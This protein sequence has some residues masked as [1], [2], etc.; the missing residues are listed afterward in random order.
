MNYKK[1]TLDT[2]R[3]SFESIVAM[4]GDNKSRYIEATIVNRSIPVDLTGCTV[5]F[6]AIKP[7]ITDIFNDTVIS[8]AKGGK[9]QIE[10]TNQTL[11]VPGVIQ[12]TLVIL[13]EDMQLS[14]L[15]FFITVIENPYNSNAIESK[16]EYKALNNALTI[17]E[18]YAKELQDA[19]VNLEEKYT[20]RLNNFDSQLDKKANQKEL[21]IERKRID[22]F[23]SLKED[24][25]T[26]DAELIDGRV[27]EDGI[28]YENIGG[29]VRNQLKKVNQI[30]SKEDINFTIN[31]YFINSE[32]EESELE[33][34]KATDFIPVKKGDIV[35][36]TGLGYKTNV[37]G[38]YLFDEFKTKIE[39]LQIL[40]DN[41]ETY[42]KIVSVNGYI[43]C[44]GRKNKNDI[45]LGSIT[46]L[47]SELVKYMND[48]D[49]N[50]RFNITNSWINGGYI[51]YTNGNITEYDGYSYSDYI[52]VSDLNGMY[53]YVTEYYQYL[54]GI[55]FYDENKKFI[56]GIGIGG[57]HAH[58]N[59]GQIT[60]I[61]IEG[62]YMR[63]TCVTENIH[64]YKLYTS[65]K[66]LSKSINYF[67]TKDIS[68]NSKINLHDNFNWTKG[69]YI[70]FDSGEVVPLSNDYSYSDFINISNINKL[71]VELTEY[72][73][74]ASGIA[75][76]D[77]NK[78][79][80]SGIKCESGGVNNN[81][82][83][84]IKVN[85]KG[86]YMRITCKTAFI[87]KFKLSFTLF[88]LIFN[89]SKK[90]VN[91]CFYKDNLNLIKMFNKIVC[92]G[93]SYT[94]GAI[95]YKTTDGRQLQAIEKN[96]SYP[97][98]LSK[99]ANVETVNLGHAG[100]T[101]SKWFSKYENVNL[102]GY[103][104]AIIF[105]GI[106]DWFNGKALQQEAYIN[107]INK[108]RNENKNIRIFCVTITKN[109]LTTAYTLNDKIKE[110]ALNNNCYLLDLGEHS[111][112]TQGS[113][114]LNGSHPNAYGYYHN[115]EMINA[116][117]N[118]I[119]E[120]NKSDFYNIS[121]VGTDKIDF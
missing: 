80:I 69:S 93:D 61:Q 43:R 95:E 90:E 110:V 33:G 54:G 97:T 56:N 53:M 65:L 112:W 111:D 9:A 31:G 102:S 13:K 105:L 63:L 83:Q 1:I 81:L 51:D 5:K 28:T 19:S 47:N 79:F 30:L 85:L 57:N 120:N 106:N 107:I 52:D 11:A 2:E 74:Y 84:I 94:E 24:S 12:A 68:S 22:S 18:G 35:Q 100:Y 59:L 40:S 86:S 60:E 96:Y 42:T 104:C 75:F 119:I 4:Q 38:I 34:W 20:T 55:A 39:P 115:A 29:A 67:D 41:N 91:P 46:R 76:Y 109:Y 7:D 82:G 117:I 27:G 37:S 88:D 78:K 25:T 113:K 36:I 66:Q 10:L 17:V 101:T 121:F 45:L 16:S 71:M 3:K 44:S 89:D 70:K 108:L 49:N 103:D 32:G 73:D 26:G 87:P 114:W 14:V 50:Y 99:I 98:Q 6:S 21:E 62:K 58:E 15:P 72:Y 64:E 118:Y 116:Y 48:Y 23:T 77:E 92:I 8:D